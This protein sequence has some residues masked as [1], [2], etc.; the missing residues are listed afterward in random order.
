MNEST[1]NNIDIHNSSIHDNT[2]NNIQQI[3]KNVDKPKKENIILAHDSINYSPGYGLWCVNLEGKNKQSQVKN[4]IEN[5]KI[6]DDRKNL[7]NIIDKAKFQGGKINENNEKNKETNE[8]NINNAIEKDWLYKDDGLE[9]ID[10]MIINKLK[11]KIIVLSQQLQES[12]HKSIEMESDAKRSKDVVIGY[13]EIIDKKIIENEQL[14]EVVK[15]QQNTLVE[16]NESINTAKIEIERKNEHIDKL[17]EIIKE[18][19]RKIEL[20]KEEFKKREE[21]FNEEN[22]TLL[23]QLHKISVVNDDSADN[24]KDLSTQIGQSLIKQSL[25]TLDKEKDKDKDKSKNL[26]EKSNNN[27]END[28]NNLKNENEKQKKA[29]IHINKGNPL[30]STEFKLNLVIV[31]LKDKAEKLESQN[32]LQYISILNKKGDIVKLKN[33]MNEAIKQIEDLKQ[34]IKWKDENLT[35]RKR[36]VDNLKQKIYELTCIYEQSNQYNGLITDT[37]ESH[38][39]KPKKE[40]FDLKLDKN[41]NINHIKTTINKSLPNIMDSKGERKKNY[42]SRY[43]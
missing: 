17:N 18:E 41:I 8:D 5:K 10:K 9:M 22:N 6:V 25:Q 32:Q 23:S 40:N 7:K 14:I 13:K 11:Q 26:K 39:I 15:A 27:N 43:L 42:N 16:L 38:I 24:I 20:V 33:D 37:K 2:V 34:I 35:K 29:F 30:N 31:D 1:L 12:L 21:L 36:E 4:I 19:R 3:D 28:T